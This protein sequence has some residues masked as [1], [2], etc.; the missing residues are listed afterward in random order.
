[1]CVELILSSSSESWFRATWMIYVW[2]KWM[3]DC[4]NQLK[5]RNKLWFQIQRI[6]QFY[7]CLVW[8]ILHINLMKGLDI[9]SS[10]KKASSLSLHLCCT[11]EMTSVHYSRNS[12]RLFQDHHETA[13]AFVNSPFLRL[14]NNPYLFDFS[15]RKKTVRRFLKIE[16]SL[17]LRL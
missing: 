3:K 6:F 15:R 11:P 1:M 5:T 16:S 7:F 17:M 4:K 14:H 13:I 9:A 8:A 2:R 12:Y 10:Q